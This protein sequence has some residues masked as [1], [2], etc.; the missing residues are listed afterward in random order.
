MSPI[1]LLVLLVLL[2]TTS[3]IFCQVVDYTIT[4]LNSTITLPPLPEP[5][6]DA[7][8]SLTRCAI[9]VREQIAFKLSSEQ[10]FGDDWRQKGVRYFARPLSVN[11]ES[12]WWQQGIWVREV[13]QQHPNLL[14]FRVSFAP[15][16]AKQVNW[17]ISTS[18]VDS[19]GRDR[20]PFANYARSFLWL[21]WSAFTSVTNSSEFASETLEFELDYWIDNFLQSSNDYVS[22]YWANRF[23]VPA[24]NIS[25]TIVSSNFELNPQF[26]DRKPTFNISGRIFS[27]NETDL[28]TPLFLNDLDS[29]QKYADIVYIQFP[30]KGGL[31]CPVDTHLPTFWLSLILSLVSLGMLAVFN[32][33]LKC[34]IFPCNSCMGF[35]D[36]RAKERTKNQDDEMLIMVTEE[37]GT[38]TTAATARMMESQ[39]VEMCDKTPYYSMSS[40][41]KAE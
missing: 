37:D 2:S 32:L 36:L 14:D 18:R 33:C 34:K 4:R 41:N 6:S 5:N 1:A 26:G 40:I 24:Y 31:S 16:S 15:K 23:N 10:Q 7:A 30:L 28:S 3:T 17:N 35:S 39:N 29:A 13:S 25:T 8:N 21:V 9:H 11:S 27:W 22:M 12:A 19:G 20:E 38:A